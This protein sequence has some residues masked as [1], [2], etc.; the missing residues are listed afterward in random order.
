MKRGEGIA[1]AELFIAIT[2]I[3][4]LLFFMTQNSSEKNYV[5]IDK[6]EYVNAMDAD[7][8]D[9]Y[10]EW[11]NFTCMLCS[12]GTAYSEKT[13]KITCPQYPGGCNCE[14]SLKIAFE[15]N[16]EDE[17][18]CSMHLNGKKIREIKM[19]PG[20]N[21]KIIMTKMHEGGVIDERNTLTVCCGDICDAKN[22]ESLC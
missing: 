3:L 16:F 7:L 8:W 12:N 6:F 11:K 4:L 15:T 19:K 13:G 18:T 17:R 5:K 20:R 2:G 22:I 1:K 21:K 14:I 9:S 10:D